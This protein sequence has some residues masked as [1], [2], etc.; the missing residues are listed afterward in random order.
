MAGRLIGRLGALILGLIGVVIAFIFDVTGLLI[1]HALTGSQTHG[2]LGILFLLIGLAGS[3]IVFLTPEVAALLLIVAAIGFFFVFSWAAII[4]A[5]FFVLAA[6]L[7]Y[8]DRRP[9][10]ARM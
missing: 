8:I 4:P 3:L 5:I 10:A 2:W 7:A 9:A 1:G 6:I